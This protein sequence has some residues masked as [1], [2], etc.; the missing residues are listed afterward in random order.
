[1]PWNREPCLTALQDMCR[2]FPTTTVIVDHFSNLTAEAGAPDFGVDTLLEDLVQFPRV[3]Q[4]F[5]TINFGKLAKVGLPCA[6]LVKRVVQSYGAQRVMWGSDI[7]QSTGTYT[8]MVR[9]GQE[10][11]S[12][13]DETERRQVQC[14]AARAVYG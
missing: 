1:M 3:F 4:K 8:E 5:T 7:A 14:E 2:R 9:L 6:P 11:V 13:L 10:A 12:L